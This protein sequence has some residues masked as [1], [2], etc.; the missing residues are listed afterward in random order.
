MTRDRDQD[1]DVALTNAT[2]AMG[3]PD[4]ITAIL[5]I[6]RGSSA[7]AGAADGRLIVPMWLWNQG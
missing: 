4:A 5:S 3:D 1:L 2:F 6:C 7:L